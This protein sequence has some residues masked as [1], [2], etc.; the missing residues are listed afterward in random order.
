MHIRERHCRGLCNQPSTKFAEHFLRIC[1][2]KRVEAANCQLERLKVN[3]NWLLDAAEKQRVQKHFFALWLM[4]SGSAAAAGCCACWGLKQT[5]ACA[6]A[7]W[8]LKQTEL[9]A[10]SLFD[11]FALS[12]FPTAARLNSTISLFTTD[13][14]RARE[15]KRF[16][17]R[18]PSWPNLYYIKQVC[19]YRP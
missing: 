11:A 7:C 18:M 10:M 19:I 16:G 6:C 3:S 12:L 5:C 14:A 8:G 17:T 15:R 9:H 4:S 13:F 1:Q 2:R